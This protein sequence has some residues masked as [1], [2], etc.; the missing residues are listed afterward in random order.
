MSD[1]RIAEYDLIKGIGIAMV[2]LQ[3]ANAPFCGFYS[4]FDVSLFY[5]VAGLLY[6]NP[7]FTTVKQFGEF[8]L[9]KFKRIA[10]PFILINLILLFFHNLLI[11]WNF[12]TTNPE[13]LN[14]HGSSFGTTHYYS[15]SEMIKQFFLTVTLLGKSQQLAGATWFLKSFFYITVI[16]AVYSNV[17]EWLLNK[18]TTNSV[19]RKKIQQIV[20]SLLALAFYLI[21]MCYTNKIQN[22]LL[23]GLFLYYFAY[24]FNEKIYELCRSNL[25]VILSVCC[26]IG[27]Y[28]CP[29]IKASPQIYDIYSV[30]AAICGFILTYKISQLI[31][32]YSILTN[33]ISYIG[34]HT[35]SILCLHFI[36]F[37]VITYL[38]LKLVFVNYPDFML[39]AFPVLYTEGGMWVIYTIFA[40][41]FSVVISFLFD[42]LKSLLFTR[43]NN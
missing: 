38:Q 22:I 30:T 42:K 9:K 7:L 8:V 23:I 4:C 26:L 6:K 11:D 1:K 40:I 25:C 37:K 21:N 10:L 19:K 27:F 18:I 16:I 31:L 39:S 35:V 14:Y 28:C 34:Q 17:M 15:V 5:L 43:Q 41:V 24:L 3:H 29:M 2:V 32:K 12:Y 36:G 13:F 33:V 20:F